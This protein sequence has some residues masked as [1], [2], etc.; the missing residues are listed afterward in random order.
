[1]SSPSEH[2]DSRLRQFALDH[3]RGYVEEIMAL[4]KRERDERGR[5]MHVKS[6]LGRTS[7]RDRLVE[8][9]RK[10]AAIAESLRPDAGVAPET[11]PP[12]K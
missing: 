3:V 8:A 6:G 2:L 1:M 5:Q 4:D 10:W 12:R 11:A 7:E 9:A